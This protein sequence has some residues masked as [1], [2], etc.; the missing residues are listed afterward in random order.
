MVLR[1]ILVPVDGSET[2][3]SALR[4]ALLVGREF[5]AHVEALHVRPDPRDAVPLVGEGVSGAMVEELIDL[6][7]KEAER[8]RRAARAIFD[9]LFTES[10][11]A[12]VKAPT[13]AGP[14]MGWLEIVGR[15][16]EVIARKGRLSD[17]VVVGRRMGAAEGSANVVVDAAL[18]D[19]GR[20]LLVVPQQPFPTIGRRI[21]IAWNDSA[22]AARTVQ[23]ALP[24]ALR[25][26]SVLV[27]TV[28]S[29]DTREDIAEELAE[30]LTWHGISCERQVLPAGRRPVATALMDA[31]AGCDLFVMGAY[32]H[33]RLLE[34]I[35]GGVTRSILERAELPL[36]M[37]H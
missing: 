13:P 17:L 28:A 26:K 12:L 16:S 21:A 31:S 10:G 8:D 2:T 20:P 27:L 22:E 7:E 11:I 15:H 5:K 25:A 33:S 6:T 4:A 37:A 24:F 29:E 30:Y 14:S 34:L 18:F 1:K 23:A 3:R 32:T 36:L 9:D 19:T 35:M